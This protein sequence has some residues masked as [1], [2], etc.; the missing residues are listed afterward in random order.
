MKTKKINL[1]WQSVLLGM[2]LCMVLVFFLGGKAYNPQETDAKKISNVV[3]TADLLA[4]YDEMEK[5]IEIMNQRL[6]IIE[7]KLNEKFINL[8]TKLEGMLTRME[9]K[10]NNLENDM[11]KVLKNIKN[12]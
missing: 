7:T 3:T 8:E 6:I 11:G 12:P 1:N 5:K 4:K 10:I 2:V 9:T